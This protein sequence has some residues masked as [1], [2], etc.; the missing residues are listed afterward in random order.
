MTPMPS[1]VLN[2]ETNAQDQFVDITAQL[3]QA[4]D[5]AG[6][7]SG[8]CTVFCPHTTAGLTV[9]EHA[10]PAVARDII[11]L[12]KKAVPDSLPWTHAEGN[13]PAHI[14]ASLVGSSVSVIVEQGKLCLG[15]WQGVFLCEFDGPR[16]RKVWV[17]LSLSA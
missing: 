7:T 9:N 14:K 5:K 17:S 11:T 4:I 15:T 16:S 6:V 2:I 8:V 1:V 3:Q 13:S 10:D 12:M